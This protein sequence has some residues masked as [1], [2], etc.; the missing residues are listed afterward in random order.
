MPWE[1]RNH[2][3]YYYH[4]RRQGQR[5]I[6][7]YVGAG[8]LAETVAA[9][10]QCLRQARQSERQAQAALQTLH[11]EVDQVCDLIQILTQASLLTAGFHTHKGQW[12]KK[13]Q[14]KTP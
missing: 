1:Q 14:E 9:F 11:A 3:P 6:S 10:D 8:Q 12:R 13:H 5:V 2:K 7:E 4:K